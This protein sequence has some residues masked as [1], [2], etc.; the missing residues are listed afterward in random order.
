[1][2]HN[3]N[4]QELTLIDHV[5]HFFTNSESYPYSI[6]NSTKGNYCPITLF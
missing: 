3:R 4:Y 2:Q 6:M 1:M 5:R